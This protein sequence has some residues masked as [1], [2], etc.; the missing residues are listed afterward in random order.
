MKKCGKG[1]KEWMR[2]GMSG[3]FV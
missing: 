3:I 1:E 2:V